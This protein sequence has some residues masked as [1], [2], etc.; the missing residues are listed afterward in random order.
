MTLT[1]PPQRSVGDAG[2]TTDHDTVYSILG[3]SEAEWR[4]GL[5]GP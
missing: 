3:L 2:H 1:V 5:A 4:A